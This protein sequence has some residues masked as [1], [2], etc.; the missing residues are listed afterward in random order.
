MVVG[1]LCLFL[2]A[3]AQEKPLTTTPLKV[4]DKLPETFWQQEHTV[5]SN[6]TTTT[7]TLEKYKGKLLILDFWATWCGTCVGKFP[8]TDSVQQENT[9]LKMV[10]INSNR[11]DNLQAVQRFY[12]EN[13]NAKAHPMPTIVGDTLLKALFPHRY[14][15]HYVFIDY[16][17]VVMGLAT[18]HFMDRQVMAG[19]IKQH[20]TTLQKRKY[21]K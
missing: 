10:L 19:L 7:E 4:G 12:K 2:G 14:V 1:L 9:E 11:K 16:R 20:L 13:P 17:G 21:E 6:G 5:Y 18:Y 3:M 8:I 15:P